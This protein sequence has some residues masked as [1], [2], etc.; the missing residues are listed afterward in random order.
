M[1]LYQVSRNGSENFKKWKQETKGLGWLSVWAV[2]ENFDANIYTIHGIL[3]KQHNILEGNACEW[4]CQ[5]L[6]EY[7]QHG[8]DYP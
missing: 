7:N 3:H 6:V 2:L 8:N 5:R 4:A 1:I